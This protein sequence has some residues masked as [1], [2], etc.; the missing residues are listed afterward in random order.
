MDQDMKTLFDE[1]RIGT[2]TLKNRII[3]S[4][5]WE[6]MAD[7]NGHLTDRLRDVYDELSRGGIGLII[8]GATGISGD[9]TKIPRM[10]GMYDDSFIQEYQKLT[11]MIHQNGAPVYMQ[12]TYV[13]R[14][15]AMW[16]PGD[17]SREDI[18]AMVTSFGK[19]AIRAKQAGFDGVQYHAAH[20]FF[21]SQFQNALKNTRNDEY[22]GTVQNRARIILEIYDEIRSRVGKAFGIFVKINCSDFKDENDGVFETCQYACTQLATRGIQ[23]IE[24]SGG[25][26][27]LPQPS[28]VGYEESIFRDYASKIADQVDVPIILV[29]KNR[30][31]HVMRDLLNTTKIA[32]FSISRPFIRQPDLINLW[33]VSPDTE[34]ECTSCDECRLPDGNVCPFR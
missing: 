26:G 25:A 24:I 7:N 15:G 18:H 3:R 19:A 10:M 33:R 27:S 31:F 11:G 12:L 29:G 28:Q 1:T 5:T 34:P 21:V 4:A 16:S 13:G 32:Y 6:G 20:G 8:T 23:G 14:N 17:S 22:G 2:I 30:N 9:G